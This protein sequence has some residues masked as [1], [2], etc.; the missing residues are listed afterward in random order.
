M[1][2]VRL[3][4]EKL[5]CPTHDRISTM[6]MEVAVIKGA[7]AGGDAV[8]VAGDLRVLRQECRPARHEAVA[9]SNCATV[10]GV[11]EYKMVFPSHRREQAAIARGEHQVQI[12]GERE[13][14]DAAGGVGRRSSPAFTTIV[15]NYSENHLTDDDETRSGTVRTLSVSRVEAKPEP[16]ER[17]EEGLK[18]AHG[19]KAEGAQ[20]CTKNT[21]PLHVFGPV[22]PPLLFI[23][24]WCTGVSFLLRISRRLPLPAPARYGL[25]VVVSFDHLSNLR[26]FHVAVPEAEAVS[27]GGRWPGC[28]FADEES[29]RRRLHGSPGREENPSLSSRFP[30]QGWESRYEWERPKPPRRPDIFP[31]F[32]PMKTPLPHPLPEDPPEEDEEEEEEQQQQEEE[33]EKPDEE[34]PEKPEQSRMQ[35]EWWF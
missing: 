23:S 27:R 34:D 5:P 10:A 4:M 11:D 14:G 12:E 16:L 28:S 24:S 35:H 9:E 26:A 15:E 17:G 30:H 29:S 22:T 3:V 31:Q 2:A 21:A 13:R 32:S 1:L 20:S 6:P 18:P 19:E 7:S 33:E 8:E 25:L